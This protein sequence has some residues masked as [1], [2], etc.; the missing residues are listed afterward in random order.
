VLLSALALTNAR[1][2]NT[3]T[4][5]QMRERGQ[6]PALKGYSR[7][8]NTRL[9]PK[10]ERDP[11]SR[12]VEDYLLPISTFPLSYDLHLIPY[13]TTPLGKRFTFDGV[14]TIRISVNEMT[15][16]IMMHA[17]DLAIETIR[18]VKVKFYHFFLFS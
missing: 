13:L 15:N 17:W 7:H 1:A 10:L 18:V 14:V 3:L 6:N 12:V 2:P 8:Q 16:M 5:R 9:S 11:E 4:P